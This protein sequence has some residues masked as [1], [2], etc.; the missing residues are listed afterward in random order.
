MNIQNVSQAINLL[1]QI[2]I[3]KF[4]KSLSFGV[5]QILSFFFFLWACSSDSFWYD[6]FSCGSLSQLFCIHIIICDLKLFDS[7]LFTI[8]VDFQFYVS[9]LFRI[10]CSRCRFLRKVPCCQ[11]LV[12][13]LVQYLS[14]SM[15][16]I[17]FFDASILGFFSF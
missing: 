14:L 17:H 1:A 13:L 9:Y 5:W 15:T 12:F 2:C 7:L 10:F 3:S 8:V 11:V 6:F 4:N 16:N